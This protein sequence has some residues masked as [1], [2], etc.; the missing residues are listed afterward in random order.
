MG[1]DEDGRGGGEGDASGA[2]EAPPARG[3]LR[4]DVDW[5]LANDA[6]V[7]GAGALAEGPDD[8]FANNLTLALGAA[9]AAFVAY[10]VLQ[11]GWLL[12]SVTFLAVKYG[13]VAVV[14]LLFITLLT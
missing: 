5:L 14:L 4:R 13:V 1:A 11:V 8:A 9:V 12:F 7:S 3:P 6:A 2:A 10:V